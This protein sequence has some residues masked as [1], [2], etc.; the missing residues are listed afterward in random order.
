MGIG[1]F[2]NDDEL[3][4]EE[5]AGLSSG[6]GVAPSAPGLYPK[7]GC[8]DIR[9]G[10][11]SLVK[12]FENLPVPLGR[13]LTQF[14]LVESSQLFGREL[15]LACDFLVAHAD[16]SERAHAQP[17]FSGWRLHEQ[18]APSLVQAAILT[19]RCRLRG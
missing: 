9:A 7:G 13:A 12:M 18:R 1:T 10:L 5:S 8:R 19:I 16:F 14:A 15:E 11:R 3:G 17:L 2:C 6:A 4:A